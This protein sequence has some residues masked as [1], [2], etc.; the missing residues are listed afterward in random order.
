VM[1]GFAKRLEV[2]APSKSSFIKAYNQLLTDEKY[3]SLTLK[4]TAD[5][6][7]V[8]ERVEMST[9]AFSGA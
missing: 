3:L 5:E 2:N 7:N 4:S 6:P 9:K 1:V 8:R